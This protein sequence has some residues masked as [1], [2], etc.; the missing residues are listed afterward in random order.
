MPIP[1]TEITDFLVHHI[2][3]DFPV[4]AEALWEITPG[5]EMDESSVGEQTRVTAAAVAGGIGRGE[6]M[7]GSVGA[8]MNRSSAHVLGADENWW[9]LVMRAFE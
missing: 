9:A 8:E 1:S 2:F 3:P 5:S 4:N 7:K 6:N